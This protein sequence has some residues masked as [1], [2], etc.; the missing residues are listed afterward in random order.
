M[1]THMLTISVQ[2]AKKNSIDWLK[3][4]LCVVT[5]SVLHPGNT[6]VCSH[7][8]NFTPTACLLCGFIVNPQNTFM[9]SQCHIYTHRVLYICYV[10]SHTVHR[11]LAVCVHSVHPEAFFYI[12]VH[13]IINISV[14]Q[15]ETRK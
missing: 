1:L 10:C 14:R 5:A 11:I 7:S 8:I 15:T 3:Y 9:S 4:L 2:L 6:C 13:I 12:F